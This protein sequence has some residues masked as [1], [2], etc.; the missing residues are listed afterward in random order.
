MKLYKALKLKKSLVGEITKLKSKI[1]SCNCYNIA[2]SM[3]YDSREL[4]GLMMKKINNLLDLK[5]AINEANNSIQKDIYRLS[6]LK[7]LINFLQALNVTEGESGSCYGDKIVIYKSTIDEKER[8][9]MIDKLQEE[10]DMIQEKMD[11][12]NYLVEANIEIPK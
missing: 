6:E 3:K 8:D 12:F 5:L 11:T 1:N 2:N 10:I 9:G 7:S 4:Y